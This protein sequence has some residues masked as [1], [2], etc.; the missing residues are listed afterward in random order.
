MEAFSIQDQDK[1]EAAPLL[2]LMSVYKQTQTQKGAVKQN[3]EAVKP[4]VEESAKPV[5]SVRAE[6]LKSE[7]NKLLA[8]KNYQ[9]AI[10]KY[11]EGV[12]FFNL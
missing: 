9:G 11:T 10:K 5:D 2:K 6:A 1:T 4:V 7:G 8:G 12:S 3:K